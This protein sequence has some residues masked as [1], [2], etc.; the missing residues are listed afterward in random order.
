M[1]VATDRKPNT[2][3]KLSEGEATPPDSH[4]A[5]DRKPNTGLKLVGEPIGFEAY[6]TSR[7]T[8]NPTR[9]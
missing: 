5:T 1:R 3:L 6:V 4:V 8:E 7:R 9:D 2:G